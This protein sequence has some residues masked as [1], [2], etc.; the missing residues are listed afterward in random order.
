MW[1]EARDFEFDD[2]KQSVAFKTSQ[3]IVLT[4]ESERA[5]TQFYDIHN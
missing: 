4:F 3:E 2:L 1:A 5:Y